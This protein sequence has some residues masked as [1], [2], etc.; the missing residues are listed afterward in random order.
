[1]RSALFASAWIACVA[2]GARADRMADYTPLVRAA[3]SDVAVIGKVTS[4]EKETVEASP[5]PSVKEKKAYT[6]AVVKVET[7]IRGAKGITHLKVGFY[8]GSSGTKG[9][10]KFPTLEDGQEVCLFL[11]KHHDANFYVFPPLAP[12]LVID[13][14]TKPTAERLRRAA[15]A[16]EDPAK[17]LKAEKL[18]DRAEAACLLVLQYRSRPVGRISTTAEVPLEE[19][20]AILKALAEADWSNPDPD[21][22][23]VQAFT[24]LGIA[25]QNGFARVEP[26][27]GD[28]VKKLW[29]TELKRWLSAEGKDY[30]IPKFVPKV[31]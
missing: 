10:Y 23:P 30:R 2:A 9:G 12:P 7:N 16:F 28:D 24:R 20:Q 11:V 14:Q 19:S 5:Y 17:A 29:Q 15:V 27:P 6:I 8:P 31:K 18:G 4:I 25:A 21:L 22:N 26:R 13:A 1:M 3:T